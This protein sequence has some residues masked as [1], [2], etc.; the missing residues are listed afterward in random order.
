V[1]AGGTADGSAA[2]GAGD[3]GVAAEGGESWAKTGQAKIANAIRITTN[4]GETIRIKA[5]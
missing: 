2:V 3:E 4:R 1:A 5:F